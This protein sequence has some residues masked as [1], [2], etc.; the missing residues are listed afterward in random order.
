MGKVM[1]RRAEW[2]AGGRALALTAL[3]IAD[4]G[5]TPGA[6]TPGWEWGRQNCG[7]HMAGL[8]SEAACRACCDVGFLTNPG[9]PDIWRDQ[10]YSYCA[11]VNWA[12]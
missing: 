2:I 4:G 9:L 8:C 12:L 11:S 5:L 10:W 7:P 3:A 1:T 6:G